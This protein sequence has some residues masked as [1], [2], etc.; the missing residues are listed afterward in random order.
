MGKKSNSKNSTRP[1]APEFQQILL[2]QQPPHNPYY[3]DPAANHLP[4]IPP[5][6]YSDT[7]VPITSTHNTRVTMSPTNGNNNYSPLPSNHYPRQTSVVIHPQPQI[8]VPYDRRADVY[9]RRVASFNRNV[10]LSGILAALSYTYVYGLYDQRHCVFDYVVH[11]PSKDC[12][13]TIQMVHRWHL[14]MAYGSVF[15]VLLS[16]AKCSTGR[17]KNY[18]CYLFLVGI[19]SLVATIF[20]GYLAYL[21][22]YSPC[23]MKGSDIITNVGK[24]AISF[25]ADSLPSPDKGYFNESN[26]FKSAEDDKPGVIIFLVDVV[27]FIAYFVMFITSTVLC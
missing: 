18:S 2:H 27:N 26:V 15:M 16:L 3:P 23:T 14:N 6:P 12:S 24:T 11:K 5:P 21:A 19:C 7:T 22:F 9:H 10:L 8:A 17:S 13:I 25:I 4:H 20:S 1:N